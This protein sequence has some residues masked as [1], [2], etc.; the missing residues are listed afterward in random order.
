[1]DP[2]QHQW[3]GGAGVGDEAGD[4]RCCVVWSVAWSRK[5][6]EYLPRRQAASL[7]TQ[8]SVG[9]GLSLLR[10]MISSVFKGKGGMRPART[11]G[12]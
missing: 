11:L 9:T 7:H 5:D 8:C 2:A 4:S 6:K 12:D 3:G 1:M 10:V